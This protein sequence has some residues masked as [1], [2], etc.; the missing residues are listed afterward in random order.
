MQCS[1]LDFF[2]VMGGGGGGVAGQAL[3]QGGG[4]M[5]ET[6]LAFVFLNSSPL[7]KEVKQEKRFN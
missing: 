6:T 4:R 1:P 3:G 7:G 2:G 5:L